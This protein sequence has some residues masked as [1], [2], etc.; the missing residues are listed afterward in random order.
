MK[1]LEV[2]NRIE[3]DMA[4]VGFGQQ[5]KIKGICGIFIGEEQPH[6]PKNHSHNYWNPILLVRDEEGCPKHKVIF[7]DDFN[8][9]SKRKIIERDDDVRRYNKF[10]EAQK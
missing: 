9:R 3:W 1:I 8:M 5:V 6:N 7:Y 10:M 2:N 4:K